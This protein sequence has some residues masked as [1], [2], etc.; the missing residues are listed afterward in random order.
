MGNFYHAEVERGRYTAMKGFMLE[1]DGHGSF[2][3]L[4]PSE[5]GF[6]VPGDGRAMHKISVGGKEY[7]ITL[8][9]DSDLK[10][11]QLLEAGVETEK[12]R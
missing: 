12:E 5:T 11:F 6:L 3:A 1:G 9:N 2:K 8:E 4:L 7:I 10:I